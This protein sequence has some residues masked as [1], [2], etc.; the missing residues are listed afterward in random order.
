VFDTNP[1]EARA[2]LASI[3]PDKLTWRP[4]QTA[5]CR[6]FELTAE[7]VIGPAIIGPTRFHKGASP[8]GVEPALAT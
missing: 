2:F 5:G 6:F 8:A 3:F 1:E 4:V 7:A